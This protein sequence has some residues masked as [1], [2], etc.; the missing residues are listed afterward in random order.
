[1][2]IHY[3]QNLKAGDIVLD[4]LP[5]EVVASMESRDRWMANLRYAEGGLEFLVADLQSWTPGQVVRVAF[6]GGSPELHRAVEEATRPISETANL[7]LDF[8]QGDSYRT[9]STQDTEYSAEIRV[10][11]DCSGYFSLVGT[12]SVDPHIGL[13]VLPVGGA[14]HQRSLNLGGFNVA[15]PTGWEGTT[16]HEFLHALGVHHEHQNMRGP[17]EAAFRWEDDLGYQPARDDRG[18]YVTDDNGLRPGIY[19]YLSGYPNGWSR[20]KVDANL[21]TP[22]DSRALVAGPFDPSSVMLY[23]FPAQ[24]YR[25]QPSPCAPRGDGQQLSAGDR[26]ALELL[27]P[28]GTRELSAIADRRQVLLDAIVGPE[29]PDEEGGLESAPAQLPGIA[30][31]AAARLRASLRELHR[32]A[33]AQDRE[34]T[35]MRGR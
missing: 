16:L 3:L 24:F 23:R 10:S 15:L 26:R 17:C 33:A 32:Q 6:L 8:R 5:E 2:E 4:S 1:M 28:Q 31:D 19:S 35:G 21:R 27:Y 34:T 29:G 13:P 14:P 25:T 30:R 12:D 7:I 9:W 20:V 18:A 11:F 22:G